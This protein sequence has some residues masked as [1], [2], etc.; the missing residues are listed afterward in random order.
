[1]STDADAQPATPPATSAPR[2]PRRHRGRRA[3]PRE[4][5]HIEELTLDDFDVDFDQ[6]V[7]PQKAEGE[8]LT[9]AELDV[10]V[11]SFIAALRER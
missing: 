2:P 6:V 8:R 4:I 3:T 5:A 10:A 9:T 11:E 7:L 1:V